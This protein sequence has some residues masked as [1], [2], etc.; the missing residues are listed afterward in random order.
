MAFSLCY[1]VVKVRRSTLLMLMWLPALR[2]EVMSRSACC[3]YEQ[4]ARKFAFL[5]N[6]YALSRLGVSCTSR[7]VMKWRL[8][9]DC[10]LL[11]KPW[12]RRLQSSLCSQACPSLPV[13]CVREHAAWGCRWTTG[14]HTRVLLTTNE[15]SP[16]G[17]VVETCVVVCQQCCNSWQVRIH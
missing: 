16:A 10:P 12:T 15:A 13:E 1:V 8:H 14:Q 11:V 5:T 2:V 17:D 6:S 4:N 3:I 7:L 9:L